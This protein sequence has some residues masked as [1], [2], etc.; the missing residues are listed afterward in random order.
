M[1]DLVFH[2]FEQYPQLAFL[3]SIL[4]SVIIAILGV[5]PSFFVTAATILFFGFW[6]GVFISFLGES[7]GAV[8]AFFLYR[9]GFKQKTA[10]QLKKFPKVQRL[11][12]ATGKEAFLL[13]LS[14]RLIP[15]IP[16]G[17]VSFAA[18]IG[19]VTALT[20]ILSSSL[21]KIPALLLEGYSV[22][23]V[24]QFNWQG[25]IILATIAVFL[26]YLAAKQISRRI[27]KNK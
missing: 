24:T 17:L 15:F 20:F 13:I 5:V 4:L 11:V 1:K 21:G 27:K 8:V 14:M 16:S 2:L 6:Q 25:K 12:E 9:K 23:Q 3:I 10:Y 22:Y 26:F 19:R 7:V 18:A